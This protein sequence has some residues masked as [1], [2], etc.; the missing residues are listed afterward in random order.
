MEQHTHTHI[1]T[2]LL[3]PD[4]SL[5]KGGCVHRPGGCLEEEKGIRKRQK[6]SEG[7]TISKERMIDE[8]RNSAYN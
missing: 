8:E 1:L 4:I 2:L 7:E 5:E 3:I 6:N